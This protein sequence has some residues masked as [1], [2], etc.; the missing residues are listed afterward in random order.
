MAMYVAA[1]Q[2]FAKIADA[3]MGTEKKGSSIQAGRSTVTEQEEVSQEKAIALLT[4]ILSDTNGLASIAVGEKNSGMY[5]STV[6]Q[7]LTN[8]L[9]ARSTASIAELGKTTTVTTD[10][11]AT[12]QTAEKTKKKWVICTELCKQGRLPRKYYTPGAR[13][14]A[15][16]SKK[17]KAGYFLWAIPSVRHLKKHPYSLYSRFMCAVFNARAENIAAMY[18]VPEARSTWY[19]K[20]IETVG[21]KACG[22]IGH[23]VPD[24]IYIDAN[25]Y[26]FATGD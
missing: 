2:A 3:M 1:A 26:I 16:Y 11:S 8:D 7:Q 12:T 4:K 19:G 18:G 5:N 14:F 21:R 22:I 9:L 6:N 17:E 25:L 10:Q 23:F 15:G 20:V 13:V 24:T